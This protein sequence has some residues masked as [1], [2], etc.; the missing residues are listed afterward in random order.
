MHP[1]KKKKQIEVE[2]YSILIVVKPSHDRALQL[3]TI[4]NVLFS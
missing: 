3:M 4:P 2:R 1:Q